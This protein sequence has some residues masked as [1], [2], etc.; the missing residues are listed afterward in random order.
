MAVA[1][2]V[3]KRLRDDRFEFKFPHVAEAL[4]DLFRNQKSRA[5]CRRIQSFGSTAAFR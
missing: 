4:A 2:V 5:F 3:S 1:A